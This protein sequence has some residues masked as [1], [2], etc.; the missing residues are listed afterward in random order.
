MKVILSTLPGM[1]EGARQAPSLLRSTTHRL[2]AATVLPV[3]QPLVTVKGSISP[4]AR[5]VWTAFCADTGVTIGALL[6]AYAEAIEQWDPQPPFVE[7]DS[8]VLARAR[9]ITAERRERPK[10]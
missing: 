4:H 3:P 6:E 10:G 5:D 9:Q 2:P 7:R 1:P 8:P